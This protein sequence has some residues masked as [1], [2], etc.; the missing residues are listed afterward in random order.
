MMCHQLRQLPPLL[1]WQRGWHREAFA[2]QLGIQLDLTPSGRHHAA[3][4][5]A[6]AIPCRFPKM[7]IPLSCQSIVAENL[8]SN[9]KKLH[10]EACPL[11]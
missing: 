11:I 5:L 8:G 2:F 6:Y 7:D 10:C 9:G 4:N 3:L 1:S